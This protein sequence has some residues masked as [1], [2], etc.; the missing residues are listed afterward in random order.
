MAC[1]QGGYQA[2]LSNSVCSAMKSE[3][4]SCLSSI[5]QCYSSNSQL[6]CV[7][8]TNQCNEDEYEPLAETGLNVYDLRTQCQGELCYAGLNDVSTYLNQASVKQALGANPQ[9]TFQ[10]CNDDINEAFSTAGDYIHSFA[11]D[12][13]QILEANIPIL[14]Y[15]GDKDFICNWLGCRAWTRALEWPGQSEYNNASSVPWMSGQTHAGDVTNYQ[16]FTF[17]RIYNAG[18][19]VPHDQPQAALTM[20]NQWL[21]GDYSLQG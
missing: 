2:V 5:S 3:I 21:Q 18:H 7:Q 19:M 6:Q 17:L 12:V 11:P 20:L 13:A 14:I 4:P 16:H 9:I 10:D 1:G 15:A 8:A